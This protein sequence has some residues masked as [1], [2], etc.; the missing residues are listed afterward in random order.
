MSRRRLQASDS[1]ELLLDTLCNTFGGVLFI[2]IL[3]VVLLQLSSNGSAPKPHDSIEPEDLL[4]LSDELD[5]LNRER[6]SLLRGFH[7]LPVEPSDSDDSPTRRRA[8][9]A[10]SKA[11]L[12]D[13]ERRKDAALV[14]TGRTNADVLAIDEEIAEI[15]NRPRRLDAEIEKLREQ[16]ED[17]RRR[18]SR[19]IHTPL[20]HSTEKKG[21]GLEIR[22]GRMYLVHAYD[23]T[24]HRM[25]PNLDEFTLLDDVNGELEITAD[26]TR[27]TPIT[28]ESDWVGRLRVRLASFDPDGW[29]LDVAV[30]SGS[31]G[32]FHPFQEAARNLGYEMRLL[33]ISEEGSFKDRG[34]DR[35]DVQ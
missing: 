5:V 4:D 22:Y 8:I 28:A 10:A 26:P 21:L 11:Q 18:N 16:I 35:S 9:L 34:G 25:G 19:T 27:G 30:R 6:D 24:G 7:T 14:R 3:V 13:A 29:F 32:A 23:F 33:L 17:I 12:E 31:F 1:L 20:A 15:K 2:A